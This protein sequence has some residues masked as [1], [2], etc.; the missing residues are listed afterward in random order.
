MT[1]IRDTALAHVL[2]DRE[3]ADPHT[4]HKQM[5]T[6]PNADSLK[7]VAPATSLTEV[8]EQSQHVRDLM[9]ACAE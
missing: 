4:R 5:K 1:Q 8:L 7:G 2:D 3:C 9:E 6:G